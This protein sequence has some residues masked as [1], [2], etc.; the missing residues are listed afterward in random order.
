MKSNPTPCNAI[1]WLGIP[2]AANIRFPEAAP[3]L[4]GANST[5]TVQLAPAVSVAAQVLFT[6]ANPTGAVNVRPF[7][8]AAVP[9]F[10]KVSVVGALVCP[11]P[12]VKKL[13]EAGT[14]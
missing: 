10:V 12:V 7:T 2:V 9:S 4:C 14:T 13:I 6:S 1:V 3:V 11:T 8:L 5:P